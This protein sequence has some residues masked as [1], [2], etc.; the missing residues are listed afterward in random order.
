MRAPQTC[1]PAVMLLAFEWTKA[2]I[3]KRKSL[4][5]ARCGLLA[6]QLKSLAK[7]GKS[8]S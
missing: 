2:L 5:G 6:A 3:L 4:A 8:L 7:Q 1:N